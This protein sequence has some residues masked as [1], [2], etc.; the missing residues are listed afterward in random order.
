VVIQDK[1]KAVLTYIKKTPN[2]QLAIYVGIAGLIV[3]A[4]L[5][6]Y[7]LIKF[8]SL[9]YGVFSQWYDG[10]K[11]L[12]WHSFKYEISNYT[13]PYM[14]SLF[15]FTLVPVSKV[16]AIKLSMLIFDFLLAYS[17]YLLVGVF[18]KK[19]Y[20]P[21]LAGLVTLFLPTVFINSA[22]WAQID[23]MFTS[24]LMLS[25]YAGLTGKSRWTWVWFGVAIAIKFQAVFFLP[26]LLFLVFSKVKWYDVWCAALTFFVLVFPPV[27]FGRSFMNVATI[28]VRQT[29]QFNGLLTLSAPSFYQ[30]L[31]NSVYEYFNPAG[32]LLTAAAVIF[33]IL[34]GLIYKKYSQR[35]LLVFATLMLFVIPFLLPQ[36][37]ERYFYPAEISSLVVAFA[38]PRFAWIAV[39]MQVITFFAYHPFLFG[40]SPVPFVA[41]TAGVLVII[42]ALSVLYVRA[43]KTTLKQKLHLKEA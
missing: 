1:A 32:I 42:C 33:L 29:E 3:I 20:I 43:G 38:F 16:V 19:N 18:R 36:M 12:G 31:P 34:V 5:L 22:F 21:V 7:T 17:V 28:Y 6:R 27:L 30:W 40:P 2:E 25:L 26:I 11:A 39:L 4:A 24:F 8:E 10:V 14:Y 15:F 13:A 9:D 37:H 35:E 23:A 41:L